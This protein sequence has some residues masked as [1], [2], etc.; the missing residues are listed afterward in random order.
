MILIRNAIEQVKYF[1]KNGELYY[2]LLNIQTELILN[3]ITLD[4]VL[5]KR[6][7]L[8]RASYF[9]QRRKAYDV[10]SIVLWGYSTRTMISY[11]TTKD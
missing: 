4:T 1:P 10:L 3:Q 6:L 9:K 8:S 7:H 5:K 2:E 11:L